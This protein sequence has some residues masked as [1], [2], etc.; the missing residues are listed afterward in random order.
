[1]RASLPDGFPGTGREFVNIKKK[2]TALSP[3]SAYRSSLQ[4][5]TASYRMEKDTLLQHMADIKAWKKVL[6][7]YK[8]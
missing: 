1:M 6:R 8:F 5:G 2:L 4:G 3:A 7:G